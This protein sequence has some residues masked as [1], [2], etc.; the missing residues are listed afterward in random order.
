MGENVEGKGDKKNI[1]KM[2][3]RKRKKK[4]FKHSKNKILKLEKAKID[5]E[6]LQ[7]ING[8]KTNG[9]DLER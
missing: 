4:I 5:N 1:G 8:L 6:S 9:L 2:L 3:T 7:P